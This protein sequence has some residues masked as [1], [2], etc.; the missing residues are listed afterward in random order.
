MVAR[1]HFSHKALHGKNRG[2][3]HDMLM[4]EKGVNWATDYTPWEK[5]GT[6]ILADRSTHHDTWTYQ[7]IGDYLDGTLAA[8]AA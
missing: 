1:A 5:N 2:Q 3:L 8:Q 4:L 6:F 7:D